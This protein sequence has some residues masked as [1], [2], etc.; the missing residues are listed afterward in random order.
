VSDEITSVFGLSKDEVMGNPWAEQVSWLPEDIKIA[1]AHARQ[2]PKV[3]LTLS[4]LKCMFPS[5]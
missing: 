4:S 1:Q 5:T 3:K 2:Q